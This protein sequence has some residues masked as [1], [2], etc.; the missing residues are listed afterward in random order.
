MAEPGLPREPLR[1]GSGD[2]GDFRAL[3]VEDDEHF[4]TMLCALLES[5]FAT[6][7][8]AAR[9]CAGARDRMA[10][11]RYDL[12]TIDLGLPDGNGLAFLREINPIEGGPQVVVI[13]GRGD[14]KAAVECFRL[15]ASGYVIKGPEVHGMLINA[16]ENAFSRAARRQAEA[17]LAQS[18]EKYRALFE[19]MVNGFACLEI[20]TT[21]GGEAVDFVFLEVNSAF[22]A[23]TGLKAVNIV[24][25][26]GTGV[27]P[28][29][30]ED[31]VDW[32]GLLGEVATR[33]G[34][35]RVE[36]YLEAADTHLAVHAYSPRCGLAAVVLQD[37]TGRRKAEEALIEKEERLSD[38]LSLTPAVI[39]NQEIAGEENRLTFV[40]DNVR[41]LLGQEPGSLVDA[42][43]RWIEHIHP[44]DR[45]KVHHQ[46]RVPVEAGG[47][48]S[49]EYRVKHRD[50]SWRWV[51][52]EYRV[53]TEDGEVKKVYGAWWDTS[54]RR[55]A[56]IG[57]VEANRSLESAVRQARE[58]N[59]AKSMFLASM[60]HEIRTPIN[61]LVGMAELLMETGLDGEQGTCAR[62]ILTSAES[63][64][65]IIDDILDF[66]RIE[67]GKLDV[68]TIDFDLN[69]LLEELSLTMALRAR[70][71]G[72]RLFCAI[73]PGMPVL[74]R[75]D[76]RRVRQVLLNLVNNA[77]KFTP[78]G[79]VEIS[80]SPEE[81]DCMPEEQEPDRVTLCFR[82]ADT[83]IGI[84]L[85]KQEML[86]E[87]FAQAD[88][89]ISREYGGTGLGLAISRKL[90]E[91]MGG[92]MGVDSNTGRGSVFW[93]CLPFG[94]QEGGGYRELE[95]CPALNGLKVLVADD[96]PAACRTITSLL[97]RWG[98]KP[99]EC[100]DWASA[101]G[102][103]WKAEAGG[104]PFRVVLARMEMPGMNA[105][106][107]VRV[108]RANP[109]LAGTGLVLLTEP[110]VLRESL[111]PA[112]RSYDAMLS[113]PVRRNDLRDAVAEAVEAAGTRGT[114]GE[115]PAAGAPPSDSAAK[116][117]RSPLGLHDG[118]PGHGARVLVV[119]DNLL[120]RKVVTGMLRKFG[121]EVD[122][123]VNGKEALEQLGREHYDLVMMD[124]Q[125]PVLNGLEATMKI[126]DPGSGVLDNDVVVVAMT[127]HAMRGVRENCLQAGMND[128][129][130]KPLR[131][132]ALADILEK[133]LPPGGKY[134]A[135]L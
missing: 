122:V 116:H 71:R 128:Y 104:E 74:L 121:M 48:S 1:G 65:G 133:W 85:E 82:V 88:A 42:G 100:H 58:A 123:S 90:V 79:E 33:G 101:L 25:R 38:L 99:R 31:S 135:G 70:H 93:F 98:M 11:C 91:L 63:L 86:F 105:A 35:F 59:L 15:G 64:L 118:L 32:I 41:H 107:L 23:I 60:S 51:H 21:A 20:I 10:R 66:S 53:V 126:R 97:D 37:I 9:D 112:L 94:L 73:P 52:D 132:K 96:S 80:V 76:P 84:P 106:A 43:G 62:S 7:A 125:M 109:A 78:H 127:A 55:Q 131:M 24:G 72:L 44:E 40:S 68:E 111:P 16:I 50:G 2:K 47:S 83:G 3:V 49:G 46:A 27:L 115:L 18:E 92:R 108:T 17:A 5:R 102:M 103:M 12:V 119:D 69:R 45:G 36:H 89:S 124:L 113:F 19:R 29:I 13:T 110:G 39:Y 4:S 54:D 81:G 77:I 67:A 75:G 134:G 56:E 28:G 117:R 87:E 129:I 14:E 57:L 30:R 120:S 8:D 6:Q 130:S 22:E 61:G 95:P 114:D 34:V 26:R